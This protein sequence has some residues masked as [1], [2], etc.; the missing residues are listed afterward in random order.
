MRNEVKGAQW[1]AR[2]K[3]K[4]FTEWQKNGDFYKINFIYWD[5]K[6]LITLPMFTLSGFHCSLK[7]KIPFLYLSV[8]HVLC[9]RLCLWS[10][11]LNIKYV[12]TYFVY[13]WQVHSSLKA[14]QETYSKLSRA[15]RIWHAAQH[16]KSLRFAFHIVKTKRKFKKQYFA[17]DIMIKRY[18]DKKTNVHP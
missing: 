5:H 4:T 17:C 11:S 14:I 9:Y 3:V 7:C 16:S 13:L 12:W 2:S 10:V 15:A 18:Y 8:E 1:L 6:R